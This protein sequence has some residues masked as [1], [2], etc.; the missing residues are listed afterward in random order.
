MFTVL[1]ADFE[2]ILLFDG[3]SVYEIK[4]KS[5]GWELS[6]EGF[7]QVFT[8]TLPDMLWYLSEEYNVLL[9]DR[10]WETIK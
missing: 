1:E 2:F 10:D 5:Y 9:T 6:E 3:L 4:K 7:K 8:E